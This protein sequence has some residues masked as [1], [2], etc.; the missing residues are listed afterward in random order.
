MPVDG[1]S[2][3]GRASR[4]VTLFKVADEERVVS[5]TRFRDV[6]GDEENG[7]GAESDAASESAPEPAP[8]PVDAEETAEEVESAE[9]P[10]DTA[11]E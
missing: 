5:V 4:G 7:E 9:N 2:F 3:T 10:T 6:E 1:I 11:E 8:E